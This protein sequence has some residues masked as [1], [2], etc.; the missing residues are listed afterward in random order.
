MC[1]EA[2]KTSKS[3]FLQWTAFGVQ[4]RC[5]YWDMQQIAEWKYAKNRVMEAKSNEN[6][7]SNYV[8]LLHNWWPLLQKFCD[9]SYEICCIFVYYW[10]YFAFRQKSEWKLMK[11]N[12]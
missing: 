6:C 3:V 10:G 12:Y 9:K 5:V 4:S 2:S 7:V 11:I 8:A 1:A